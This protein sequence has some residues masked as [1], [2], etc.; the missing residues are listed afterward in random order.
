MCPDFMIYHPADARLDLTATAKGTGLKAT[1]KGW[2]EA[3]VHLHLGHRSGWRGRIEEKNRNQMRPSP[4][5]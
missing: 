4:V 2:L 5:E 3:F 1:E